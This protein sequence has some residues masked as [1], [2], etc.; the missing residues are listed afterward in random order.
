MNK[1]TKPTNSP[2]PAVITKRFNHFRNHWH[3]RHSTSFCEMER[4]ETQVFELERAQSELSLYYL[5]LPVRMLQPQNVCFRNLLDGED[6]RL[7]R[8]N[9]LPCFAHILMISL[10]FRD[11]K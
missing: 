3:G 9:I 11:K 4:H 5:S 10:M 2:T 8:S 1:K 7:V 6:K